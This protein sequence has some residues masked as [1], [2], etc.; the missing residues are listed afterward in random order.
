MELEEEE[1]EQK[2]EEQEL[3]G[4]EGLQGPVG[5]GLNWMAPLLQLKIREEVEEAR[6]ESS[7]LAHM[8]SGQA[9]R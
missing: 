6:G 3:E 4:E 9:W 5:A 7:G 1:Q 8:F 2:G